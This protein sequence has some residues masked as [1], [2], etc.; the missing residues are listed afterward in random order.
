MTV[1]ELVTELVLSVLGRH[2][3]I[4]QLDIVRSLH[5]HGG[6]DPTTLLRTRESCMDFILVRSVLIEG[7]RYLS[8]MILLDNFLVI[9]LVLLGH[10]GFEI[11]VR[12]TTVHIVQTSLLCPSDGLNV[13]LSCL[14][15]LSE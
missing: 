15:E 11:D 14:L 13:L 10:Q 1:T 5:C 12:L 9:V 6:I 3:N 7:F 2:W 8:Y 4:A